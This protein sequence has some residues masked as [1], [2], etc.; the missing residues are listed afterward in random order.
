[1]KRNKTY[2]VSLYRKIVYKAWV[3]RNKACHGELW[4]SWDAYRTLRD[5]TR[6]NGIQGDVLATGIVY[7]IQ[8]LYP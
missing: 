7:D 1:M 4:S 8:G 5:L 6:M 2:R 3:L